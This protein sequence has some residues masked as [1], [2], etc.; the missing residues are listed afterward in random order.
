MK[1]LLYLLTLSL[2]AKTQAQ[3]RWS[4]AIHGVSYHLHSSDSTGYR[5]N[6][7]NYGLGLRRQFPH[8]LA[9]QAGFYYNSQRRISEYALLD[10][11]PLKLDIVRLGAFI[12]TVNHYKYGQGKFLPAGGIALQV[13]IGQA[14]LITR[15]VPSYKSVNTAFWSF[16]FNLPIKWL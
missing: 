15:F 13:P 9:V 5:F 4:V 8:D 7:L 6:D 2:L 10:W 12:G 16:E 14:N 3:S 11:L 1:R